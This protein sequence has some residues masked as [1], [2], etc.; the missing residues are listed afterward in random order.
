MQVHKTLSAARNP[1]IR[2]ER[3]LLHQEY[4]DAKTVPHAQGQ[5]TISQTVDPPRSPEIPTYFGNIP[6]I[7]LTLFPHL[8]IGPHMK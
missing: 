8:L 3:N 7:V 1:Q 6:K 4:Q 5:A 2:R